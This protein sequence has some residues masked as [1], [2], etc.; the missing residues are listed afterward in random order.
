MN[1]AELRCLPTIQNSGVRR[2]VPV[3]DDIIELLEGTFDE[4]DDDDR[5]E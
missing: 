2:I 5:G 4:D 1:L 3:E